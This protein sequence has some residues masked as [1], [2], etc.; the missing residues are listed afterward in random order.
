MTLGLDTAELEDGAEALASPLTR[1]ARLPPQ[2]IPRLLEKSQAQVVL[3]DL[4]QRVGPLSQ[5]V[6][7]GAGGVWLRHARPFEVGTRVVV[8]IILPE[9]FYPVTLEGIVAKIREAD[10][11]HPWI[12]VWLD[13]TDSQ[14][15]QLLELTLKE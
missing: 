11:G 1:I 8:H 13:E 6:A 9:Q 2:E 14:G 5:H 12:L 3:L 10:T 7:E 4:Y 15:R